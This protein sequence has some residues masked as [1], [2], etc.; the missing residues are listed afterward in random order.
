MRE[1]K[2]HTDAFNEYYLMG[3]K[4]SLTVLAGDRGVSVKTTKKWSAEF[5]WQERI[6]LRDIE[7]GR[8]TTE[9]VDDQIV[10]TKADYRRD[11]KLSMQP[12]KAAINS[13]I[14][15]NKKTGKAKL[16]F[17]VEDAK[18]LKAMV[19]SLEKLIKVDL[20]IMG[21]PDSRTETNTNIAQAIMDGDY[22][23]RS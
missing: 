20:V 1:T 17:S 4:R 2:E 5:N 11:I 3:D 18:D 13:A 16:N 12:V 21:E 22:Y 14:I 15:K 8:K 6:K 7:I 10:N 19:D 23:K 9:K